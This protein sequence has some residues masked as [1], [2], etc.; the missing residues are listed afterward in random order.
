ME[1]EEEFLDPGSDASVKKGCTCPRMD[2][3][4]GAGRGG[5]GLEYG[6]F[7][8]GNCPL[9]KDMMDKPHG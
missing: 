6:W 7:I 4:Y 5:D 8:S 2:N 1:N 9:H 3:H